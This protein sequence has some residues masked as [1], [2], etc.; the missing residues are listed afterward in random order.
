MAVTIRLSRFGS[1]KA[2]YYRIMVMDSAKA[3]D[4]K[5]IEQVGSYDP[6]KE[7]P[8]VKLKEEAILKWLETG[9]RPSDTVKRFLRNSGVWQKFLKIA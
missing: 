3:R 1:K 5:C 4:G 2:P 9:A 6:R 7:P 8:E